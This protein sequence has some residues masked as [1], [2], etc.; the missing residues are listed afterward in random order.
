MRQTIMKQRYDK[1]GTQNAHYS[2]VDRY[3]P[4]S[5]SI[6]KSSSPPS[7]LKA[8]SPRSAGKGRSPEAP[9]KFGSA[10]VPSKADVASAEL[11]PAGV[12][13]VADG[14]EGVRP[15]A[16]ECVPGPFSCGSVLMAGLGD[17]CT[18]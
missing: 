16:L 4:K 2:I 6:L 12:V 11:P 17:G 8:S 14:G 3:K 15:P 5:K 7:E 1:T 9:L 13:M 10:V 18:D